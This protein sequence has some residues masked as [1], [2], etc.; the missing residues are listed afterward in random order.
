MR[1]KTFKELHREKLKGAMEKWA[2]KNP[3][4]AG[5]GYKFI[6]QKDKNL[7]I[8]NYKVK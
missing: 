4:P 6:V 3:P 7:Y 2:K 5:V 1:I 8:L